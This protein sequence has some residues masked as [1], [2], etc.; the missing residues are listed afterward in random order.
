MILL[1]TLYIYLK[2][3]NLVEEEEEVE[4]MEAKKYVTKLL[5]RRRKAAGSVLL[6]TQPLFKAEDPTQG[7]VL[8]TN[9]LP[10]S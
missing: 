7:L 6:T 1:C 9:A 8:A 2:H 3:P 5:I 10:L 4:I